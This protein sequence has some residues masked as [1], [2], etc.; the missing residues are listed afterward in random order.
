M[1]TKVPVEIGL[2]LAGF[3]GFGNIGDEA[4]LEVE[5]DDLRY[6]LPRSRIIVFSGNEKL[7]SKQ[8]NVEAVNSG[9]SLGFKQALERISVR[10]MISAFHSLA[11]F[12]V[13][14]KRTDIL[15]LGGGT[16]LTDRYGWQYIW[17]YLEKVVVAKALRKRVAFY[18]VGVG[19]VQTWIGRQLIRIIVNQADLITVR[20]KKSEKL[21]RDIGVRKPA[22]SVS[23]D[24]AY[25]LHPAE[26][27]KALEILNNEGIKRKERPLVGVCIRPWICVSKLKREM[28]ET[29]DHLISKLNA[30]VVFIPFWEERDR[31]FAVDIIQMMHHKKKAKIIGH[32]SPRE[33][34]AIIGQMDLI[35]GMRLHSLIFAASMG[36]P[37]AGVVY[38]PKVSSFLELI[39]QEKR[40]VPIEELT[41]KTL[42]GVIEETWSSRKEIS[43]ELLVT[44]DKWKGKRKRIDYLV[45]TLSAPRLRK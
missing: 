32:Y 6:S 27:S 35:I 17:E 42:L 4:I 40:G 19:P 31:E 23:I 37:F 5:L 30:T 26:Q 7:T 36:V 28:A 20:D 11:T 41:S 18:S 45:L 1:T 2:S 12:V 14:L 34:K 21:L 44:M 25:F 9:I 3:Y 22:I 10:T 16:L 29:M 24:P 43:N 15:I 39:G 38:D 13:T 33:V 8:Y